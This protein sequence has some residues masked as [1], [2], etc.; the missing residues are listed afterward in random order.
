MYV[1]FDFVMNTL[2]WWI[3]FVAPKFCKS[4]LA[5]LIRP[6]GRICY[7]LQRRVCFERQVNPAPPLW[8]ERYERGLGSTAA[9][10]S[11]QSLC[12]KSLVSIFGSNKNKCV[13]DKNTI[14]V[15]TSCSCRVL[16]P[17]RLAHHTWQ[18]PCISSVPDTTYALSLR[19]L[20]MYETRELR[21]GMEEKSVF[22]MRGYW[23][24]LPSRQINL[25]LTFCL[26]SPPNI[27]LHGPSLA[28]WHF[29]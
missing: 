11:G 20:Q 6:L 12:Q 28:N 14:E 3:Q 9:V 8:S 27:L 5:Y 15:Y 25:A 13:F 18:C 7:C 26:S 10:Q 2:N 23:I 21:G 16:T 24:D 29:W 1:N 4:Q 17:V 22:L 19:A